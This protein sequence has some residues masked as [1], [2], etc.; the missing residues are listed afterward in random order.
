[1]LLVN[2]K[3]IRGDLLDL[4]FLMDELLELLPSILNELEPGQY[5]GT[6]PPQKSY[7]KTIIGRELY[8]FSWMSKALGCS[9]YF[10]FAL[11]EKTLWIV[12]F[13]RDRKTE[14]GEENELP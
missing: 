7:E 3:A 8:A 6:R 10:K 5:R 4:G 13:H 12:S 2:A 9:V 11:K 14:G 1:M